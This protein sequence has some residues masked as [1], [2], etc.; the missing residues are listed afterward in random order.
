MR[1]QHQIVEKE[2]LFPGTIFR[3]NPRSNS[4]NSGTEVIGESTKK[5]RK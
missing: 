5:V 4:G 1:E 3:V 2:L